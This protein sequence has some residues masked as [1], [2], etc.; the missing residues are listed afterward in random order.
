[1]SSHNWYTGSSADP[2]SDPSVS[3]M[4]ARTPASKFVIAKRTRTV[5]QDAKDKIHGE[6]YML[7][8]RKDASLT[9][10]ERQNQYAIAPRGTK[11]MIG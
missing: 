7:V 4:Y 9:D 6:L 1:V 5:S 3:E 10:A 2:G 11:L 8:S